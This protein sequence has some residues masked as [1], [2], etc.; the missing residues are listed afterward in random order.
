MH[1]IYTVSWWSS[2]SF[3]RS[4]RLKHATHPKWDQTLAEEQRWR[5]SW[6]LSQWS[7]THLTLLAFYAFTTVSIH[8]TPEDKLR[9]RTFQNTHTDACQFPRSALPMK[10]VFMKY[11]VWI[12]FLW[13]VELHGKI[14]SFRDEGM[15]RFLNS[16]HLNDTSVVCQCLY[17]EQNCWKWA[18]TFKNVCVVVLFHRIQIT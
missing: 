6:C 9:P 15:V 17:T 10:Y 2:C 14:Q 16:F 8:V 4:C 18:N 7:S 1:N 5:H 13:V 12:A 3:W 11:I